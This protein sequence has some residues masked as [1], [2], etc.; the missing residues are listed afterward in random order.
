MTTGY[1]RYLENEVAKYERRVKRIR[2]NPD[3]TKLKSN[4][5][6]Y[7]MQLDESI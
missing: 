6:L 7:E 4:L 1:M 3:P 5:M 2:E